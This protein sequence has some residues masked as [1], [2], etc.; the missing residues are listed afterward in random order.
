MWKIAYDL[1]LIIY[2][3]FKAVQKS[4][5]KHSENQQISSHMTWIIEYDSKG[6]W[7]SILE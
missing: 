2:F 5:E 4:S 6:T 3:S 1:G 7:H